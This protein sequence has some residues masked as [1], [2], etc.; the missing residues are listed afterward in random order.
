V[1][2]IDEWRDLLSIHYH[3]LAR[4][5]LA[6]EMVPEARA[7]AGNMMAILTKRAGEFASEASRSGPSWETLRDEHAATCVAM[8]LVSVKLAAA[9]GALVSDEM[10]LPSRTTTLNTNRLVHDQRVYLIHVMTSVGNRTQRFL[11]QAETVF[12]TGYRLSV[13]EESS[14]MAILD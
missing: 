7:A 5:R 11:L 6:V 10:L 2:R 1:G 14:R 4:A 9:A 3:T 12:E 13:S 8:L